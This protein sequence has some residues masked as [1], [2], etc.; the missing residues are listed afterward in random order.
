MEGGYKFEK[1][2]FSDY[3]LQYRLWLL[4]EFNEELLKEKTW[5]SKKKNF[6]L[7]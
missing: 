4:H 5:K 2:L 3:I 6:C 1:L 7:N